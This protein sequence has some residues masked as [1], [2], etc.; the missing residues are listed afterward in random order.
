[1]SAAYSLGPKIPFH[2]FSCAPNVVCAAWKAVDLVLALPMRDSV[3]NE[4]EDFG[5]NL[6]CFFPGVLQGFS[7][8]VGS[9]L[10]KVSM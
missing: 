2:A 8:S 1:M 10:T 9:T 7:Q 6:G 4:I 3:A 5:E